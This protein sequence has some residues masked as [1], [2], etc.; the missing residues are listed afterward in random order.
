M[1]LIQSG[2]AVPG[3]YAGRRIESTRIR[4]DAKKKESVDSD[5]RAE[6][7]SI[8][9]D[10]EMRRMKEREE[11]EM[12]KRKLYDAK[13]R[14]EQRPSNALISNLPVFDPTED[15]VEQLI[16][17]WTAPAPSN[18]DRTLKP[19]RSDRS[20]RCTSP[21]NRS[22]RSSECTH[23]FDA[24]E[25]MYFCWDCTADDGVVFCADCFKSADHKGHRKKTEAATGGEEYCDCGH[26]GVVRQT[27]TCVVH[28]AFDARGPLE[29]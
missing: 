26:K 18:S 14:E 12:A 13:L 3:G 6:R 17:R 5:T 29:R 11:E 22:T 4:D 23:K 27:V 10:Y 21:S 8:E 20:G 28:G 16:S 9:R 15:I 2:P 1:T 7:E 24:G 25:T 19:S